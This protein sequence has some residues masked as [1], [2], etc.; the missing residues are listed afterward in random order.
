MTRDSNFNVFNCI[1]YFSCDSHDFNLFKWFVSFGVVITSLVKKNLRGTFTDSW[2]NV[3]FR[4]PTHYLHSSGLHSKKETSPYFADDIYRRDEVA[5][6]S[7]S[8]S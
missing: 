1:R 6:I 4:V 7:R 3:L 8:W 2:C 5:K